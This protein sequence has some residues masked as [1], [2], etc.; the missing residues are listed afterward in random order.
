MTT[1]NMQKTIK[2]CNLCSAC[3]DV[4]PVTTALKRETSSPRHKAKLIQ[5]GKLALIFYQCSLCKA[6]SDACP[7][8]VPLDAIIQQEREKIIKKGVV[9]NAVAEMRENIRKTGFPLRKEGL[10]LV[11]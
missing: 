1:N 2:E 6:C 10:V 11:A 7:S 8:K 4:C 3:N 9:P 5:E